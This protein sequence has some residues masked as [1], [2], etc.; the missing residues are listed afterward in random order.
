MAISKRNSIGLVAAF[1]FSALTAAQSHAKVDFEKQ[2]WPVIKEH[3]VK[4]H[5]IKK[6]KGKL[7]LTAT[8]NASGETV[9]GVYQIRG[10]GDLERSEDGRTPDRRRTP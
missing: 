7:R 6:V 4:C 3:C 9:S 2:V 1:A 5:G 8:H 10:A